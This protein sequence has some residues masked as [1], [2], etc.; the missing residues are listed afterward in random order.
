MSN[1]Q[2]HPSISVLR[3]RCSKF[4]GEHR[5]R[6]VILIKLLCS[7]VLWVLPLWKDTFWILPLVL[8]KE[9]ARNLRNWW[10]KFPVMNQN[11][12]TVLKKL[13]L[14][15]IRH[16]K[17]MVS[18]QLPR[19]ENSLRLG[20]GFVSRLGLVLGLGAARQLPLGQNCPLA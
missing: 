10:W 18:G 19:E 11:K 13:F 6:S 16:E 7:Y 1:I 15:W 9:R 20:L 12:C 3:K 14:L 2:K 5:C 17:K 8:L 4:T